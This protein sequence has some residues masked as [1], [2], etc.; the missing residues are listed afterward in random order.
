MIPIT[1]HRDRRASN[2]ASIG[3][4]LAALRL[5]TNHGGFG[6]SRNGPRTTD[7]SGRENMAVLCT[8]PVPD[9]MS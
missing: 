5:V 7:F 2:R 9:W 8:T 3:P 4:S 1:P 6:Q